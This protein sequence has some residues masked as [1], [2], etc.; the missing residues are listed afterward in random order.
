MRFLRGIVSVI[1]DMVSKVDIVY[2]DNDIVAVNKPAGLSVHA[3][4]RTDRVTLVDWILNNYPSLEKVGE[5]QAGVLRPGIVHRLDR[6]TSGVLVIAKTQESFLHLKQ[7]FKD[8][9]VIKTY[10]AF[11]NGVLKEEK[12]VVDR[13]IGK[14]AKDFRL[15]SAGRGARGELREAQT[16]WRLLKQGEKYAY[17]EISPK[18]GRTH[19]I[20]VHMKAINHPLVCDT[21][22]A[23]KLDCAL[24]FS[25][26]AL[27]ALTLSLVSQDG[28]K[29]TFE[30]PLPEDFV[31][32]EKAL[33]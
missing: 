26:L 10:H 16:N 29:V 27:H 17:L 18:T 5:M 19:Q 14:S 8:R 33:Q 15:R 20:R 12:G 7:Q 2:E 1:D 32:A 21:L 13:R 11:V 30:A 25:R 28:S 3:D 4:G 6:E 31:R 24:G 22:Y 23:S 9:K